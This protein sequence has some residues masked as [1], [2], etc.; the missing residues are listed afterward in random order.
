[1]LEQKKPLWKSTLAKGS[2]LTLLLG[3]ALLTVGPQTV[4]AQT[5][6][7]QQIE[8][9]KQLPPAEQRRLAGQLGIDLQQLEQPVQQMGLEGQAEQ[10]A[11]MRR[12]VERSN[13]TRIIQQFQGLPD[14]VERL[15]GMSAGSAEKQ[16][17]TND[18]SS[19]TGSDKTAADKPLS[20]FGYELFAGDPSSFTS[21][22]DVPVPANYVLGPGDT[23]VVQ[24]YGKESAN[25]AL[26]V[27][28]DGVIQFPELGPITVI[29]Q[30][31]DDFRQS[32]LQTI[33]EQMIGVKASI[34]MG[35]LRTIRVFVLGEA[36]SP[37]SYSI[38]S[39]STITH[40]LFASGGITPIGSLRNIEHKRQGEVVGT[41]DLYD[42]LLKGDTSNDARLLPGD[43]IFIP[44]I[45]NTV[46]VAGEVK[47]P[48]IYELK[49]ERQAA[50]VVAL[51][52]GYLAGAYPRVSRL[53][54]IDSQGN[55]TIVDVDL[56]SKAGQQARVGNGD[57]L[58]VFSVL[59]TLQNIVSLSGHVK[60]PG[61]SQWQPGLRVSDLVPSVLALQPN[62]DLSNALI[63]REQMPTR[64]ITFIS[65][66]LGEAIA[67]PASTENHRLQPRDELIVFDKTTDR[68]QWL[69]DDV[70][71][72]REQSDKFNRAPV[73]IVSGQ[74]RF[75]GE[76][77]ITEGQTLVELLALA[78]GLTEQAYGLEAE[79]TRTRY[80]A[81][82]QQELEHISLALT[83]AAKLDSFQ[84][85]A[86]DSLNIKRLPSFNGVEV[87]SIA[88][89][90]QFP[91]KYRIKRG[92]TLRDLIERAGGLTE[93]AFPQG[94]IFQREALKAT[95]AQRYKEL[96]A[97][98][99]TD[100][101][102]A[103]L[104]E[105]KDPKAIQGAEG[106]LDSLESI[107]PI[108]RMVI[109]LPELLRGND[110]FDLAL[111]DGDSLIIPQS[112][113]A[114]T[115]VGE[116][117]FPTSHLYEEGLDAFDY[118]RQSGGPTY[119][120]DT[121]RIYVVKADGRVQ[122]PAQSKWFRPGRMRLEPGDTIVVPLDAGYMKPLEV[123]SNVTQII[124]QIGL[125]AAAI[126]SL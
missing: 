67:N 94:S 110:A 117:Q 103:N 85:T 19:A 24:L 50:D 9:F 52:G 71:R 112:K 74:V 18:N 111:Q 46:A 33:G 49:G 23:L 22:A 43:V 53:Q 32:L 29:G 6:T 61:Q 58:E 25:Y 1:M 86:G 124:Y 113:I 16:S 38:S 62:P 28:R 122:L 121:D 118:I 47:R 41:L 15:T 55:R 65:V 96:R 56:T 27:D 73:A 104:S 102:I 3:L 35:P 114:V 76:Y 97:R 39:L 125:G 99:E 80:N 70:A 69:R 126:A 109:N 44:P 72:L 123:W 60:R 36:V 45:G 54:R 91:G 12:P 84:L 51:A 48:A 8:Q 17:G 95:E 105:D 101:A 2:L 98:L 75:P 40:A 21:P 14:G 66:N 68:A 20:Q 77:P 26:V 31:F 63:K 13:D 115:I 82:D 78:G 92:E 10:W 34:T 57:R 90:V 116:V 37:G 11:P 30:S 108:G 119:I 88:G 42:L 87:V 7:P 100:I 79:L 93:H 89:E 64:A 59:D 120:A 106:L 5:P 4:R 107:R 81:L 83:D